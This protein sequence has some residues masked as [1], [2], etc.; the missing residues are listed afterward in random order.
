MKKL[1]FFISTLFLLAIFSFPLFSQETEKE[2]DTN[3]LSAWVGINYIPLSKWSFSGVVSGNRDIEY[4][5]EATKFT[6][7]ET[8]IHYKPADISIGGNINVEDNVIGKIEKAFGY[9][10]YKNTFIRYSSGTIRG[11]AHWKGT[12][13]PKM[14]SNFSFNNPYRGIDFLY[15]FDGRGSL[16]VGLG[17]TYLEAPLE[18]STLVTPGGKENQTEGVPVYDKS[19]KVK[20]YSF[21]FGF[22]NLHNGSA[23]LGFFVSAQDKVGFGQGRMSDS[24]VRSAEYLNP[25]HELTDTTPVLAYVEND[26]SIGISYKY[27]TGD[28]TFIVAVGY[29]LVLSTVFTFGAAAEEA[30]DLGYD[31]SYESFRHGVIFKAIAM[32]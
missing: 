2:D 21:V 24:T 31:A 16:Y 25:G 3:S 29:N 22:D 15:T 30:S 11:E 12:L 9:I 7:Y 14:E 8:N 20:V 4:D 28:F 1:L 19:F 10:G 17:Y 6:S 13:A 32:W 26:S 23:G 5:M 27:M 18:I